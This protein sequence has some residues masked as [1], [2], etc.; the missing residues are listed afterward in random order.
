MQKFAMNKM[1]PYFRLKIEQDPGCFK[2]RNP[3]IN[4]LC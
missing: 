2:T 1:E 4:A 3:Q